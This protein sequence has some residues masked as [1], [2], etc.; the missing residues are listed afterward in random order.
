MISLVKSPI[1]LTWVTWLLCT[2]SRVFR[3]FASWLGCCV[4]GLVYLRMTKPLTSYNDKWPFSWPQMTKRQLFFSSL[5]MSTLTTGL[6]LTDL[7]YRTWN[8]IYC[9]SRSLTVPSL[10]PTAMYYST[11]ATQVLFSILIA[12]SCFYIISLLCDW[13]G[14]SL[15]RS[16]FWS[17]EFWLISFS[18]ACL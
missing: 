5:C 15:L 9:V 8:S 11:A 18:A 3:C 1:N 7:S 16:S 6:P 10:V 14:L 12:V 2:S 13:D 4:V 17:W